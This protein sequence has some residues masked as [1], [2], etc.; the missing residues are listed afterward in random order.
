MERLA[1]TPTVILAFSNPPGGTPGNQSQNGSAYIQVQHFSPGMTD[2]IGTYNCSALIVLSDH[3]FGNFTFE[4]LI[5]QSKV[6]TL[7]HC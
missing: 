1:V 4:V 7:N 5:L 6:L 2:D 3:V